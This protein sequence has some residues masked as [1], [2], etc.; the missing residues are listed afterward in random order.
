MV[1]S[2]CGGDFQVWDE[3]FNWLDFYL[4]ERAE[5]FCIDC[6]KS[7]PL[8]A[9]GTSNSLVVLALDKVLK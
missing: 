7:L 9:V 8:V 1:S 4:T 5:Q 6:H 3:H 2:S